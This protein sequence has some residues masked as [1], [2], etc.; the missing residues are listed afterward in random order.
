MKKLS[1]DIIINAAPEI[2]WRV[3][4]DFQRWPEWTA[5]VSK[6]EVLDKGQQPGP[7]F[8]VRIFQPKL[9]PANWLITSWQQGHEFTWVARSLG[10]HIS[11]SHNLTPHKKGARVELVLEF[12]GIFSTLTVMLVG[13]LSSKYLA[14]EAAGLKSESEKIIS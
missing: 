8:A 9:K 2:V 14:M 5:S 1:T 4:T 6:L 10:L 12:T 7:G 3:M 13:K 11:A